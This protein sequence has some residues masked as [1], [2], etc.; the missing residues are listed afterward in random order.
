MKRFN[1]YS[2]SDD[3]SYFVNYTDDC[4]IN[5]HHARTNE[6]LDFSLAFDLAVT[7]LNIYKISQKFYPFSDI[8]WYMMIYAVTEKEK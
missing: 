8:F 5:L 3:N 7:K 2:E 1:K 6:C 4:F